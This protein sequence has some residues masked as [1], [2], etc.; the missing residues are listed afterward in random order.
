MSF[1][2]EIRLQDIVKNRK[3]K[4]GT[5]TVCFEDG[6]RMIKGKCN[7]CYQNEYAAKRKEEMNQY[8]F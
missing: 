1:K 2:S 4:I 3:K 6:K 7:K 5:C 8:K